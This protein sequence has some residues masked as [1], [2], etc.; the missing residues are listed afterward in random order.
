MED[1]IR[2]IVA[3]EIAKQIDQL[4]GPKNDMAAKRR[5]ASTTAAS[6]K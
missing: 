3:E 4:K 6:S 1:L 2:R 5:S